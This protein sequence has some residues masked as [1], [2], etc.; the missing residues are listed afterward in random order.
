MQ[1]KKLDI[2]SNNISEEG[3]KPICAK[4]ELGQLQILNLCNNKIGDEGFE[5]II[6]SKEFQMLQE[7]RVDMNKIEKTQQIS[8]NCQLDNIT[9]FSARDNKFAA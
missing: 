9:K 7:V 1:L 2:S 8:Y 6:Q 3:I 4:N 5:M